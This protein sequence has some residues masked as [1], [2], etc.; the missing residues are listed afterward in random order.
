MGQ[1]GAAV[2]TDAEIRAWT[3][4]LLEPSPL[5]LRLRA[6]AERH[7]KL[8]TR[9]RRVWTVWTWLSVALFLLALLLVPSLRTGIKPALWCYVILLQLFL[10]ARTKTLS[11]RLA[12]GF[13]AAACLA[14]PLIGLADVLVA[15]LIGADINQ[16]DGSVLVAGPVEEIGKLVPL[17][18]LVVVAR[19]RAARLS[20][21]DYLLLGGIAGLGF[22][23]VEDTIRR[24][25]AT[26]RGPGLFDL[27]DQIL[28]ISSTALPQYGFGLLPG[29]SSYSGNTFA[30]H[31]VGTAI[32]AAGI[33][34]A[35]RARRGRALGWTAAA[36]A[37]G[38]V[39]VDHALYNAGTY[40][41]LPPRLG[42]ALPHFV[43]VPGWLEGL[44]AL[45]GSGGLERP[46]LL[47]LL[48]LCIVVDV[49]RTRRVDGLLPALP[50]LAWAE[51]LASAGARLGAHAGGGV[52]ARA[53][54]ALGWAVRSL[55][56]VLHE[57]VVAVMVVLGGR[58]GADDEEAPRLGQR[59]ALGFGF[60][61]RRRELAQ[62]LG[63]LVEGVVSRDQARAAAA[64]AIATGLLAGLLVGTAAALVADGAQAPGSAAFLANLFDDLARWWEGLGPVGQ[65]AVVV[66]IAGLLT[67]VGG[68]GLLP[69]LGIASTLTSAASYGHGVATF[70]RDPRQA[71]RDFV[72]NLTPGQL[73]GYGLELAL[74]RLLPGGL[75]GAAGRNLRHL[76]RWNR[77]YPGSARRHLTDQLRRW[78]YD[79]RGSVDLRFLR[80][81]N[82][83]F[84]R[85]N[86]AGIPKSYIDYASGDLVPANPNGATT[87]LDHIVEADNRYFKGDSP[88]TSFM[89]ARDGVTRHTFG[90]H[91]IELDVP[92]LERDIAAGRV[93][94]VEVLRH[95]EIQRRLRDQARSLFPEVDIDVALSDRMRPVHRYIASLEGRLP[96]AQLE[97]L[98]RVLEGVFFNN[99]SQEALVRGVIPAQY[100]TYL[101]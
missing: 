55:A 33:G 93:Q 49:R 41:D 71:T 42:Q 64:P 79:D 21:C 86:R 54:V 57:L 38:L 13:F 12:A 40:G 101:R 94:G 14:A 35:L 30:G 44:H 74:T 85:T 1:P 16:Q 32:A 51:R 62:G 58:A 73:L 61:R 27:L 26:A 82:N 68:V 22:Q 95:D 53:A 97:E 17:L 60:L 39:I 72:N 3:E 99:Y 24:L 7:A 8:L 2:L 66:G 69:A 84:A 46:L 43:D 50:R 11:W 80:Q 70:L 36:A 67:L 56:D 9:L 92:A 20:A 31:Y 90:R 48:G 81:D 28:G 10:L 76:Y 47:V 19:K 5:T 23:A 91:E 98:Q 34:L 96:P 59:W 6:F 18:V 45:G 25:A 65:I 77:R 15:G 88:Y 29:W 89:E 75:G 87:F 78:R 52:A 4:R 100:I 37:L 83:L 63:R